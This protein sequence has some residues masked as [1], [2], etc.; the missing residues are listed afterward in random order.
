MELLQKKVVEHRKITAN[1]KKYRYLQ[2][3]IL[4]L[5]FVWEDALIIEFVTLIGILTI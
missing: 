3:T 5:F 4:A 2:L 1:H